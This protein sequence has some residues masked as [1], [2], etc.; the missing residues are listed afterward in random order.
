MDLMG[1]VDDP[2]EDGVGQGGVAKRVM[3]V[4]YW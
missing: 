1:V 2:I 3:P 4:R